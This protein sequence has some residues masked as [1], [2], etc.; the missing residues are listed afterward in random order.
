M[1]AWSAYNPG[2]RNEAWLRPSGA[3]GNESQQIIKRLEIAEQTNLQEKAK[4]A[5]LTGDAFGQYEA[6]HFS[7]VAKANLQD[8]DFRVPRV[9]YDKD[10]KYNRNLIPLFQQA[11][12]GATTTLTA[13]VGPGSKMLPVL[14]S[15]GFQRGRAIIIEPGSAQQEANMVSNFGSLVL[16]FPLS[17][18]HPA[19]SLI[20]Q[21]P[22]PVNSDPQQ[23]A[24][25]YAEVQRMKN[26]ESEQLVDQLAQ[27]SIAQWTE[28]LKA[29]GKQPPPLETVLR[30]G[31]PFVQVHPGYKRQDDIWERNLELRTLDEAMR[32]DLTKPMP[33][34]VLFAQD[35]ANFHEGKYL[36]D[37]CP[38]A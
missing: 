25:K 16:E 18:A 33:R 28:K 14:N 3:G 17:Y 1:S 23:A 7:A 13:A 24:Q 5:E 19:G 21:P 38:I 32:G 8:V 22:A 2:L 26:E 10:P 9:I 4:L 15:M 37:D 6:R 11:N 29:C 20:A 34:P 30:P 12:P 31:C 36:K 27:E 35:F